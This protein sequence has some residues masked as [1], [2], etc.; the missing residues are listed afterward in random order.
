MLV[1][2]A[3]ERPRELEVR[4]AWY[5]PF[6]STSRRFLPATVVRTSSSFRRLKSRRTY[7]RLPSG[8]LSGGSACPRIRL[9][10][11]IGSGSRR[12]SWRTQSLAVHDTRRRVRWH[13]RWSV[14]GS[15]QPLAGVPVGVRYTQRARRFRRGA[16]VQDGGA[17]ALSWGRRAA[18]GGH[19][20]LAPA[21]LFLQP[22]YL[23]RAKGVV[24]GCHLE[25]LT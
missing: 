13:R 17:I 7:K 3:D 5:A 20:L 14:E 25:D 23:L 6:R 19:Y 15:L 11:R 4:C 12:F 9:S 24:R 16:F 8:R 21:A 10:T 22:R 18:G 1:D 2:C